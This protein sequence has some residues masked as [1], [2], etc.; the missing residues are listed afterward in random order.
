MAY[1][2]LCELSLPGCQ[3]SLPGYELG[4]PGCQPREDLLMPRDGTCQLGLPDN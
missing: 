1:R 2:G 4:L 3:L